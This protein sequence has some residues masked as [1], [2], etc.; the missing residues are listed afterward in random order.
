[1]WRRRTLELGGGRTLHVAQAGEGPD[2]LLIHGALATMHDWIE[3]PA[4]SLAQ[5][6]R[7]TIVDR[8]GHGGSGRPR[9]EAT[10][11]D[12]ALHIAAA[13]DALGIASTQVLGH[14][15]GGFVALALAEQRPDLVSGLALLAPLAFPEL[16]AVEHSVLGPRAMP[17]LGPLLS[18]AG[19]ATRFDRA[20]LAL[21]QR[22]MFAPAPVPEPWL[23]A[24][25]FD[26]ILTPA[27]MA[28]EGEDAAA[29]L[30]FSPAATLDFA[31]IQTPTQILQGTSDLIVDRNR[32]ARPL[33]A[34]LP[35]AELHEI[36]AAGHMLHHSHAEAVLAA[37]ERTAN[38]GR[39]PAETV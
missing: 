18:A 19:E 5:T 23:Q 9:F 12:Q 22:L 3:G 13:L 14:S 33:A 26:Q 10:P 16:R 11:R 27:A 1:M 36:E 37:V 32:H 31:T 21:V 24:Y 34:A 4:P 28:A 2:L 17:L 20:F 35:H 7:V 6:H 15:F 39:S 8:P 38:H 29:I 30:P 25:P